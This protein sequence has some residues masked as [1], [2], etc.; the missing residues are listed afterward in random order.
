MKS[1]RLHRSL[2]SIEAPLPGQAWCIQRSHPEIAHLL[3]TSG[4]YSIIM[5]LIWPRD[6]DELKNHI[7]STWGIGMSRKWLVKC[8][9]LKYSSI[10]PVFLAEEPWLWQLPVV[11]L[12]AAHRKLNSQ[13]SFSALS[14]RQK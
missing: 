13:V 2:P 1:G 9:I 12:S 4:N 10:V 8:H 6:H 11:S 3:I 14:W 5:T 7:N